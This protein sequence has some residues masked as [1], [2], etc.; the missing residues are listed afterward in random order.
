M[1]SKAF[2]AW[3]SWICLW[4]LIRCKWVTSFL[5]FIYF[6]FLIIF[7]ASTPSTVSNF[8]KKDLATKC[9]CVNIK[10]IKNFVHH[11]SYCIDGCFAHSFALALKCTKRR[12]KTNCCCQPSYTGEKYIIIIFVHYVAF[13]MRSAVRLCKFNIFSKWFKAYVVVISSYDMK[14]A[15]I[16]T[17]SVKCDER[18][19]C[20]IAHSKT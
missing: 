12:R 10:E 2:E 8:I 11:Q 15:L 19:F 14:I 4:F 16:T 6:I 13:C 1:S 3:L 20:H 17:S 9:V 18:T 5:C 7:V